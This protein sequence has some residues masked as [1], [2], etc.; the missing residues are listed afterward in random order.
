MVPPALIADIAGGAY[1]A[2]LNVLLALRERERTG[3]GCR[4]DVSLLAAA[5]DLQTE[6]LT[7]FMNGAQAA[8][9]RQ[10]GPIAGW[11]MQGPYG[12]YEA[13][14]GQVAISLCTQAE[15]AE[16]VNE[17]ELAMIPDAENF[18]QRERIGELVA[19]GVARFTLAELLPRLAEHHVWH[20]RVR[21]YADLVADPQVRHNQHFVKVRSGQT[22]RELNLVSHPVRYNGEVPGIRLP[23]Q[24][25][26]AQSAEIL[27]EVGYGSSDIQDLVRAG[28]VVTNTQDIEGR[29]S[30]A[31]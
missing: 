12:I 2:V 19:R 13:Q 31:A 23:P 7:H 15:L 29:H 24:R 11:C 26:G 10:P 18:R 20:E 3:E 22:A 25:L 30:D 8:S 17:P 1:P 16:A 6:S 21:D 14:D 9:I 27:G 4:V 5:I 28:I